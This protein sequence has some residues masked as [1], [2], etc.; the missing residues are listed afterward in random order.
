MTATRLARQG[1]LPSSVSSTS[2]K[3]RAE[4]DR[5]TSP[6]LLPGASGA[7]ILRLLVKSCL[8]VKVQVQVQ[9]HQG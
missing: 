7:P 4:P 9:V 2:R 1:C 3:C 6:S 5:N 8:K